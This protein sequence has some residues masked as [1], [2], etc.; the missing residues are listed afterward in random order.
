MRKGGAGATI[1]LT[2]PG[3]KVLGGLLRVG[4]QRSTSPAPDRPVPPA[5]GSKALGA[6]P[7]DTQAN[8]YTNGAVSR[9][10]APRIQLAV[11]HRTLSVPVRPT[12]G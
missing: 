10:N 6:P 11:A 8:D 3:V 7:G 2:A 1:R 4:R 9:G 12:I 5:V